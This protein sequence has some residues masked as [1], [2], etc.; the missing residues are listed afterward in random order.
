MTKDRL[1]SALFNFAPPVV[2]ECPICGDPIFKGYLC[3]GCGHDSSDEK[4][5]PVEWDKLK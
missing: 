1:I 4:L 3:F 5:K 2:G